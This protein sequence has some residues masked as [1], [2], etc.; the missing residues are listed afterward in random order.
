KE[1]IDLIRKRMIDDELSN[2]TLNHADITN[3]VFILLNEKINEFEQNNLQNVDNATGVILHTNLG[4]ARL[5]DDAVKQLSNT[6]TYHSTLEYDIT[7][8][9]RGSRHD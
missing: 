8:G 4:R 3:V 6:A 2:D 1:Q 7:A 9:R 5:S